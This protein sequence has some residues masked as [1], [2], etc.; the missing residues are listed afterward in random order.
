MVDSIILY[1][2]RGA[3]IIPKSTAALEN[4]PVPLGVRGQFASDASGFQKK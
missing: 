4:C 3:P 1:R 2:T